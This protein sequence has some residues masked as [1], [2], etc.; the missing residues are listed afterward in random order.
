[1]IQCSRGGSGQGS[2]VVLLS[3]TFS[4]GGVF[5]LLC[6]LCLWALGDLKGL[7]G[8]PRWDKGSSGSEIREQER[9]CARKEE[10]IHGSKHGTHG[11]R[12]QGDLRSWFWASLCTSPALW[13]QEDG[14]TAPLA[15]RSSS[16]H[17]GFPKV[18][19]TL[20]GVAWVGWLWI[21]MAQLPVEDEHYQ[22]SEEKFLFLYWN[23][24][25]HFGSV[26]KFIL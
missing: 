24:C 15:S 23:K 19:H 12:V 11:Q 5:P 13:P 20:G 1:M 17:K 9:K 14:E 26:C 10:G 22:I 18:A 2:L 3:G 7:G 16:A 25:W 8:D 6:L 4:P 21:K